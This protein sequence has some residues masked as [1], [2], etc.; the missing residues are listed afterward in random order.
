MNPN[1]LLTAVLALCAGLGCSS[2]VRYTGERDDAG[3]AAD[4]G[5]TPGPDGAMMM[6]DAAR[7]PFSCNALC[8]RLPPTP[9]CGNPAYQAC[10]TRCEQN[11]NGYPPNCAGALDD[12]LRCTAGATTIQCMGSFEFPSCAG[13]Y[14]AAQS[15]VMRR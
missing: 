10:L 14:T 1:A 15:C 13:L 11:F 6:P 7:M 4:A 12:L 8:G 5:A 9:G 2:Y 3:A